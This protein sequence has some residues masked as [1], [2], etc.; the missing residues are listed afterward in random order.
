[1]VQFS[2]VDDVAEQTGS[3]YPTPFADI[4]APT[5]RRRLGLAVGLSRIGLTMT[6]IP[7]GAWASQLH[8]H[9][10]ED[11]FFLVIEG[12]PTWVDGENGARR[13][14]PGDIVGVAADEPVGH[15]FENNGDVDCVLL[16]VGNRSMQDVCTYPEIGMKTTTAR[17]ELGK[18]V[19]LHMDGRPYQ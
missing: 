1:M 17:Y 4:C 11:E 12:H 2:R 14:A 19:Y 3:R 5:A 10:D 7:P 15:R 13:L 6:R 18:Q 9:S 16:A 8:W